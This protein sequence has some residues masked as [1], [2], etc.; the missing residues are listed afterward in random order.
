MRQLGLAII[1][2]GRPNIA[3]QNHLPALAHVPQARLVALHDVDEAGV[4]QY[5][6][7][8][9][10][11]AY[12]DFDDVLSRDDVEAVIIASPDQ[13][14]AEHT[15]RAA[16]A[17][18]HI[19]C[20]KPLALNLTEAADMR[21]AVVEAGV[22][23]SAAQSFRYEAGPRKAKELMLAGE[24]G[25]PVYA[26]YSVKGRFYSYP[27]ESFYRKAASGGQFLH[28]G[29]HYVDLLAWLIDSL[30]RRVYGQSLAHYPTADRL[31]TDNYTLCALDFENGGFGRVEQNLTMLDPPGFPQREE[32]RLI[33]TRGMISYGSGV[34]PPLEVFADGVT[35]TLQPVA[36]PVEKNPFVLLT[37]DFV[38]A[39]L[40]E[41][42]PVISMDWSFRVLEACLGTLESCQTGEPVE[43]GRLEGHND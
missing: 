37:R 6:V 39:A 36:T 15:I 16:Q 40:G 31:E 43:L 1:G 27:A 12:T 35:Q 18:K 25:Q 9:G 13:F 11:E 17:G 21:A 42:P 14:H 8:Y 30:P 7:Q 2:A 29:P 41:Q 34:R 38:L 33:G 19:L 24:I 28:N 22:V 10:V 20:Q 23:F 32:T 26:S 4:R 3:T 5:A